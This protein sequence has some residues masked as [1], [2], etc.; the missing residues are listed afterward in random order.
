M[1]R[2]V[3]VIVFNAEE[4]FSAPLRSHLLALPGVQIAAEV[5]EPALIEQ[6]VRQLPCDILLVHLDPVPEAVLPV[7]ARIASD[8]PALAV[9]VVSS[10]TDGR[11]ILTAM[12]AGIREFLTK[13]LDRQL[14]AEAVEKALSHAS[15]AVEVGTLVSIV[16]TMGGVGASVVATNLATEL[17]SMARKRPVALVDLDF[18]Y[19]QQGT[20]L[21]LQ[22]DYTIADLCE[23]PEQL[24]AAVIEKAMVKHA[25]GVHLLA[26]PNQFAQADQIT[27]AH[28]VS[29]LGALQQ[30]YE[31]VICDGPS[32][33][34]SG[35]LAVLDLADVNLL[36]LQLLVPSVR[37]LHRML[38]ELREGGYNLQRFRLVCNRVGLESSHL[39][40]DHVEAT[41]ERKIAHQIPDDWKSVSTS[42]N[43]GVPLIESAPKSRAR[44]AIRELAESIAAGDG[45]E[46]GKG[47]ASAAAGKSGGGLLSKIFSG[48]S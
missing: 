32:R 36:V 45:G 27:A 43:M 44:L 8:N 24:D 40:V 39:A 37:N 23:T 35:G 7:A 47:P 14:L 6:A 28:C 19:G 16:G 46:A 10:S 12:R 31:Y 20:M 21:D 29:V 17:A 5:N 25:S 3:R 26:R 15:E 22:A 33:Y 11:H 30:M 42:V 34:D 18:R 48:A 4:E 41:V 13:P 1:R 2:S 38:E 9:F